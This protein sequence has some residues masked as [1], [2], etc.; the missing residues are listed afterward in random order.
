MTDTIRVKFFEIRNDNGNMFGKFVVVRPKK[1]LVHD[2]EIVDLTKLEKL[3]MNKTGMYV[4]PEQEEFFR[5]SLFCVKGETKKWN[6]GHYGSI[7]LNC[8]FKFYIDKYT[9][10]LRDLLDAK[11]FN[12]YFGSDRDISK[13]SDL[14]I[15]KMIKENIE[16]KDFFDLFEKN[17]DNINKFIIKAL[18]QGY[19]KDKINY[20]INQYIYWICPI[21]LKESTTF[22]ICKKCRKQICIK[23]V[24]TH[25][26][27]KSHLCE[28][29][30]K[31]LKNGN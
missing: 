9:R 2:D 14:Q 21:C 24:E 22:S 16:Q 6:K 17:K 1:I 5:D 12:G 15:E 13:L 23:C 31:E 11:E 28:K 25:F 20:R 3:S 26:D 30:N 4:G 29:C 8:I 18:K 7:C 10:A 19:S 27:I